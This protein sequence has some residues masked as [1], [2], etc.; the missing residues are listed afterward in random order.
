MWLIQRDLLKEFHVIL[1]RV[2][3]YEWEFVKKEFYVQQHDLFNLRIRRTRFLCD[4]ANLF[5]RT[6]DVIRN[7]WLLHLSKLRFQ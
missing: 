7:K 2:E 4:G 5:E 6:V 3:V 1:E